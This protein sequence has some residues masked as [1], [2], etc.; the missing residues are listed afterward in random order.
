VIP[1]TIPTISLIGDGKNMVT[2]YIDDGLLFLQ[3][4]SR[5]IGWNLAELEK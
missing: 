1:F 4:K 3:G 2:L 5:K